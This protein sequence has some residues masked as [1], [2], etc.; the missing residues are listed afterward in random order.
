MSI[1]QS[2]S[3]TLLRE[4]HSKIKEWLIMDE[5]AIANPDDASVLSAF[6]GNVREAIEEARDFAPCVV[7]PSDGKKVLDFIHFPI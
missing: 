3:A 6:E 2:S 1:S 5:R 4:E 7:C